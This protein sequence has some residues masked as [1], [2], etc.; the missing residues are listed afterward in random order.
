MIRH[1]VF[2]KL[3]DN[4]KKNKES[5]KK[6]ILSLKNEIH[7]I[8][9]LEVG[10]NFSLEERAYDMALIAD[11]KT[12]EDLQTYASNPIHLK[13]IESLKATNTLSKVVDY[14]L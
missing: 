11:F 6:S 7:A 3:T 4:S 14:E 12:K 2:L 5:I 8:K 13:L 1:I 10:L 9:N